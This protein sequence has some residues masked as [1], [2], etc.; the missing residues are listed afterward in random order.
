MKVNLESESIT[1]VRLTQAILFYSGSQSFCTIHEIEDNE[2]QPGK[3]LELAELEFLFKNGTSRRQGQAWQIPEGLLEFGP[4]TM[5]WLCKSRI[6]PIFWAT[7]DKRLNKFNAVKIRWPNLIF[8]VNGTRMSV[9]AVKTTR[10]PTYNTVFYKAP[11]F[12]IYSDGGICT[13]DAPK[14]EPNP[15]NI[16][17]IEKSFFKSAFS[18]GLSNSGERVKFKGGHNAFWRKYCAECKKQIPARFPNEILI[19][20]KDK[21][22]L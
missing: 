2:I 13:G 5:T 14:F 10:R 20:Q 3:A 21:I 6:D 17:K 19:P 16:E 1:T 9:W 8:N 7:K 4:G 12:N 15:A 11:F 22:R 18:H